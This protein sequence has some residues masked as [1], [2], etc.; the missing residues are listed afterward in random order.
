[1]SNFYLT[2]V[3]NE[4]RTIEQMKKKQKME[5]EF[6]LDSETKVEKI[7][8]ENEEKEINEKIRQEQIK[9]NLIDKQRR[10]EELRQKKEKYKQDLL[11]IEIN[12]QQQRNLMRF[13][14]NQTMKGS[15]SL[16]PQS[17]FEEDKMIES[18]RKQNS[19]T[20]EQAMIHE[21]NMHEMQKKTIERTRMMMERDKIRLEGKQQKIV[22]N[23]LESQKFKE[24]TQR[25]ISFAKSQFNVKVMQQKNVKSIN[26]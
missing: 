7:R 3:S 1:M 19:K 23:Q 22:E 21:S 10:E 12:E 24:Y 17:I 20:L 11:K 26:Y 5:V 16:D 4:Q 8:K 6:M 14:E 18:F 13:I 25:K 9:K 15:K 2:G